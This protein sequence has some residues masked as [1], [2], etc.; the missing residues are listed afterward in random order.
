MQEL[1]EKEKRLQQLQMKQ[2]V[3]VDSSDQEELEAEDHEDSS[4]DEEEDGDE[5][6]F[7][8]ETRPEISDEGGDEDTD[9][10][11]A[12]KVEKNGS[13]VGKQEA[14]SLKEKSKDESPM[15]AQE[16]AN[17]KINGHSEEKK[18]VNGNVEPPEKIIS[19]NGVRE[20]LKESDSV[21]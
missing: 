4:D 13:A 5:N 12:S 9:D 11:I 16:N 20:P 21:Q 10:A 18:Q 8:N 17:V 15:V 1:Q 3:L 6:S 19:K 7:N 14:E 2:E